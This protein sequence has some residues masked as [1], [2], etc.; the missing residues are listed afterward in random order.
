[1]RRY[2]EEFLI[3]GQLQVQRPI[4]WLRGP[5]LTTGYPV[6]ITPLG[7]RA[8]ARYG[9]TMDGAASLDAEFADLPNY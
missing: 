9:L 1:M 7:R 5:V 4:P 3:S 6:V 2:A 8:Q